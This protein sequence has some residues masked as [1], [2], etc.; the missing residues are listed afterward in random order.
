M[1]FLK[2]N[3]EKVLLGVVL[4]GLT[5]AMAL[6]PII[7]SSKRQKLTDMSTTRLHPKIKELPVLEMA[8]EDMSMQRVQ[9]PV[10]YDF[11]HGHN[12][13]NPVQWLK[14]P[15][16]RL[17]KVTPGTILGGPEAVEVTNITALYL[18][19]SFNSVSGNSYLVGVVN[20]TSPSPDK[21][22]RETLVSREKKDALFSVQDINGPADKPTDLV[23]KLA[24]TG[25]TV[26]IGPGKPPFSRVDGYSADLRYPPEGKSW[27]A[28][29][30]DDTL[31]FAS[32]QYKIVAITQ[33]NVVLLAPNEKKTTIHFNAVTD[34]R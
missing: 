20:E 24:E 1:E 17:I 14:T 8:F 22:R 6:L 23:L 9:T 5:V 25:E 19:L 12:L 13:A 10:K 34:T 32:G 4:L 33:T 28:K 7:I 21:R 2:K 31:N 29:R 11:T 27:H 30:K 3:Y 16:G 15:D 18:K 26:A